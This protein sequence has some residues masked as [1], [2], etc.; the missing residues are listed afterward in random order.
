VL[1]GW[2]GCW[3]DWGGLQ[4]VGCAMAPS[5]VMAPPSEVVQPL[6]RLPGAPPR[7]LVLFLFV[8]NA[9]GTELPVELPL[10]GV[11]EEEAE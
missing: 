9:R 8:P 1:G 6:A 5:L 10:W 7:G 4:T 3:G 11:P 2:S